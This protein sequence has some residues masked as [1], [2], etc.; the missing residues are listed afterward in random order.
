MNDRPED[1]A[2][3]IFLATQ[4][5]ATHWNAHL[6]RLILKSDF[7]HLARLREAFPTAVRMVE[8]WNATG[9]E[10]DFYRAWGVLDTL[11]DPADRAICQAIVNRDT[12]KDP[13]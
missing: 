3:D 13:A 5:N 11:H 4:R 6:V 7:E 8:E 1:W 10:G 2:R 9:T 12:G